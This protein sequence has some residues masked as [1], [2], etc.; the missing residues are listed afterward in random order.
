MGI[1][2]G[3]CDLDVKIHHRAVDGSDGVEEK[4][5]ETRDHRWLESCH[6]SGEDLEEEDSSRLSSV[7]SVQL[8]EKESS[9]RS[10]IYNMTTR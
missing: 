4:V 2:R 9:A 1:G 3:R 10:R 6:R 5:S 7:L 8:Q